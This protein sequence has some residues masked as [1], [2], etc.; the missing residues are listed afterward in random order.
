MPLEKYASNLL[1]INASLRDVLVGLNKGVCG[2]AL[3]MDQAGAVKGVLT[4]G[5]VR[6]ALLE[7]A[8]LLDAASEHMNT[9]FLSARAGLPRE[10]YLKLLSDR[11]RQ[12]PVLDEQGRLVDI[13]DLVD[14]W[15]KPIMEP[16]LGGNELKYLSDC[17]TS[18]WISSQG[19]YVRSFELNFADYHG[20]EH[21]LTTSNGTT[22]LH[23]ALT[24]LGIGPGDEVIVPDSTFAATANVVIH[25]G[26]QPVFVDVCLDTWTLDPRKVRAAITE[27]TKALIPVH[28]YGHPCDM[29][30]LLEIATEYRLKIVEDCA[31]A[32]GA[33]Y[34]GRLVGTYG[35]VGCYSFFSNKIITTGEGGMVVTRDTALAQRMAMLRDHGMSPTRKYWHVAAGF[36]YRMTNMQAAVGLAQLERVDKFLTRRRSIDLRY[37]QNLTGEPGIVL[38]PHTAWADPVMWLFTLRLDECTETDRNAVIASLGKRGIEARP[39]FPPLHEQPPYGEVMGSFEISER[40]GR[41]GLSLPSSVTLK[42]ADID[43]IC[44]ELK[45]VLLHWQVA[46]LRPRE[47]EEV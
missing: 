4:D 6:R 36:N 14:F 45:S 9:E 29:D 28:L 18:N 41:E 34:K 43:R 38:Q 11:V 2:L 22:A 16:N 46:R 10:D 25:C 20:V 35:D 7:G 33:R 26:A 42:D 17:I 32:F 15:R 27:R 12:L 47:L 13:I 24:A 23:L 44:A 1:P 21:A 8:D 3:L 5:D 31:E 30:A 39:F 19:S 37:R 40:L